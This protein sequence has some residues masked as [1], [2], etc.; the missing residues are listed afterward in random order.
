[1]KQKKP[2]FVYDTDESRQVAGIQS[3]LIWAAWGTCLFVI[4]TGLFYN[5][6]VVVAVTLA[7]CALLIV[8]FSM[9]R[10]GHLHASGFIL[11][12][13]V[14]GIVIFIAATGQGIRDLA[15]VVLPIVFIFAG[16]TIDQALYRLCIG[17]AL[18]ATGWLAI[19]EV[20]GW[21]VTKPLLEGSNWFYLVGTTI[22][23]LVAALAVDLLATNMRKNLKLARQEIAQRK[24]AEDV[25]R[26]SEGRFSSIF[27]TTGDV[28][29]LLDVEPDGEFRFNTVNPAFLSTT[30]LLA[31]SVIGKN[32]KEII[33]EPSLTLVLGEYRQA[34]Q[35]KTIV[36]WEET[37]DYPTGRLTAL[38]TIAPILDA[39]GTCQQ[40]VG[41]VHDI[42][43]RKSM[44]EQL[45][46]QGTHDAMTKMYNRSY[47]EEELARFER[48]RE[49]PVSVIVADVDGLKIIN[50][51]LGHAVGDELLQ[52]AANV[53]TSA[54][55][56]GD[57][58]ARTGG[59]EFAA[60]L[61]VTDS[62]AAE[63]IVARIRENMAEHNTRFPDLPV[64]FSLGTATAEKDNLAG[65]FNLADQ[66]MYAD[67]SMRKANMNYA[68]PS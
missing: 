9:L 23:L 14:L 60:L 44:E 68:F 62:A 10:G 40:L 8:P 17:L 26:V 47:F 5:D 54:L 37:S 52:Q 25:L 19:A 43:E 45:R 27:N 30:G 29:F 41:N 50:D 21:I 4:F 7:G 2:G 63:Q 67:K 46:Y 15:I 65:T 38:V 28:I 16:L 12:L 49:F 20:Y 31:E 42:T 58:L 57:V 33:P 6:W 1:M 39:G 48:G 24:H 34:I 55:R 51:T 53:L 18:A 13:V 56:A 11:V 22:I 64:K 59:D 3:A 36:R 61:P 66:R 32:V 35:E